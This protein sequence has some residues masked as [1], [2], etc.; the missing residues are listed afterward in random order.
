MSAQEHESS[1]DEFMQMTVVQLK[2]Q[3]R[4]LGLP[5]SGSKDN[6]IDRLMN[7]NVNVSVNNNAPIQY[8]QQRPAHIQSRIDR[9]LSQRLYLI[10]RTTTLA[11][12]VFRI[13][14]STSN[15]YTVTI[16]RT[17]HC[18]C[19]DPNFVCKHIVFVLCRVLNV[20]TTSPIITQTKFSVVQ[21]YNLL[22]RTTNDQS[23]IQVCRRVADAVTHGQL[24]DE[25]P[26]QTI[27]KP[28]DMDSDCP[29]CFESL[30]V[31]SSN[32]QAVA[33][34]NLQADISSENGDLVWCQ[35]T[36]GNNIHKDCFERWANQHTP[37]TCPLCR[38]IWAR[39][40]ELMQYRQTGSS[41]NRYVNLSH[42]TPCAQNS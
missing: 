14:G 17:V 18:D 12:H 9:A 42:L 34:S 37:V 25:E 1:R 36:C 23:D 22:D 29:I 30:A 3:C 21:L 26:L 32:L 5:V 13:L 11:N 2:Q 39:D 35:T 19:P 20:P 38:A 7:V 15:L 8:N 4:N 28:I 16:G 10:D 40:N 41:S 31:A 27:R 33:S 6:I 24:S